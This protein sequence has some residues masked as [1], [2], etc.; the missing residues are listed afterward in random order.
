MD[1]AVNS[2]EFWNELYR[3]DQAG[4]DLGT[5]TPAFADLLETKRLAPG[6]ILVL[7]SG[8]GYDAVLFAR[9]GFD[10]TAI[11]SSDEAMKLARQLAAGNDVSINFVQEDMFDYS[12]EISDEFDYVLEYVT[13]CAIDPARRPE[14]AAMIP[15]LLKD[16][17]KFIA[18]FFPLDD[19]PGGP[20]FSVSMDEISRLFGMKMELVSLEAPPNSV[21]PRKG[22]ELLTVWRKKGSRHV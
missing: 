3:S 7:G 14:Y 19:R 16:S 20:P 18:L 13:Y 4:W 9:H 21:N 6:K 17:G 5:P 15:S 1:D 12:L 2:P 22:K 10:V 8:K 11:D